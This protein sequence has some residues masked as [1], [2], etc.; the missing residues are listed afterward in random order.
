MFERSKKSCKSGKCLIF[1]RDTT[2]FVQQQILKVIHTHSCL[3]EVLS[4]KL[5]TILSVVLKQLKDT[6]AEPI[7]GSSL[8]ILL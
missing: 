8:K 1:Q 5:P 7:S 6:T 3:T 2:M 4:S